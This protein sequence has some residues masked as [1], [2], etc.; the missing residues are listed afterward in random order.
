SKK[1]KFDTDFVKFNLESKDFTINFENI[2]ELGKLIKEDIDFT[3]TVNNSTKTATA[4]KG[5]YVFKNM[6][7]D[8]NTFDNF[9]LRIKNSKYKLSAQNTS[10]DFVRIGLEDFLCGKKTILLQSD[11][12]YLVKF[13]DNNSYIKQL[14]IRKWGM[15]IDEVTKQEVAEGAYYECVA[16]ADAEGY[17]DV[18]STVIQNPYVWQDSMCIL[19]VD[20]NGNIIKD[21][22]GYTQYEEFSKNYKNFNMNFNPL[23]F[24]QQGATNVYKT[25]VEVYRQVDIEISI[26]NI[27]VIVPYI[28]G[29]M[30]NVYVIDEFNNMEVIYVDYNTMTGK[31]RVNANNQNSYT[32]TVE[33][34][35]Q[36]IQIKGTGAFQITKEVIKAKKL[37]IQ[38]DFNIRTNK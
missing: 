25:E 1:L 5:E 10:E 19:S 34:Y 29:R 6:P 37:S 17:I 33:L 18:T 22:Q 11:N 36:N 38:V 28:T 27:S 26:S 14:Y 16:S 7:Y 20:E 23:L 15:H 13:K 4:V 21:A 31:M 9:Q 24:K 8:S 12:Q 2:Y 3:V 35:D 32:V 30:P